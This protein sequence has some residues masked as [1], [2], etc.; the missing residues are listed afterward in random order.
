LREVSTG[1]HEGVSGCCCCGAILGFE[2]GSIRT[3]EI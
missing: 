3:F 2:G 1:D